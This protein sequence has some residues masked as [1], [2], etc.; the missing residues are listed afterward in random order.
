MILAITQKYVKFDNDKY[1]KKKFCLNKTFKDIF[2]NLNVLLF[3]VSSDKQLETVA[4]IC[5]GLIV[6]GRIIDIN[7]KYY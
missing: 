2:E 7:P 1:F 5:D 4:H 3:P 6:T